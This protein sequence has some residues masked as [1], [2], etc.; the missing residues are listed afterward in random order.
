MMD[1]INRF[2][3]ICDFS[4]TAI[5]DSLP[6]FVINAGPA[7]NSIY[8]DYSAVEL[9]MPSPSLYFTSRRPKI[10]KDFGS[11]TAFPERILYSDEFV[12]GQAND[13]KDTRLK[14]GKHLSVAGVDNNNGSLLYFKG[15][16]RSGDLYTVQFYGREGKTVNNKRLHSRISKKSSM[17]GAISFAENGDAYFIS[18]RP[19]GMGGRDIWYAMKKGKNSFFPPLNL[20]NL[21]TPLNEECVYV[22]PDGNTLYFSSNG[23]PGFGG[24]D[25]YKSVR[26][27]DGTWGDPVNMGYPVNSPDNDLYYRLT[28][29]TTLALLSSGRRGGFGGLDVYYVKKDSRIPFELSGN[30]TDAKT[31]KTLAATVRLI[32]RITGMTA[33]STNNDTIQQRY[34]LKME[35]TGNYEL[36]VEAPGYHPNTENFVNPVVRHTKL[37][38][39]FT[40]EKLNRPYTLNGYITDL[41]TGRPVAA[42][43][44][45]KLSGRDDEL[46]RTVSD[47]STGY[48]SLRIGDKDNFDLIARATTYFD[49][50][51]ALPLKNVAEEMGNKNITL[52]KSVNMYVSTG[53]VKSESDGSPLK[54][55]IS[56]SRLSSGQFVQNTVSDVKGKYDLIL[57]DNGPFLM[58]V[59]SEGHFFANRVLQFTKDSMMV[60]RNF[61]LRKMESGAKLVIENI[62]FNTGN[63][64]LRPESFASLNKLVNLLKENPKIKIE[65]SGHTD[66]TGSAAT[67]KSLSR[68]R[69]LSVRNYLISQGIAAQRVNYE[70]YG[71]DRPVAPNTTAAGR[72]ANRR[73]EIEIL[74]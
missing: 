31:G 3:A 59:T 13:A 60:I 19:G 16:K 64:T 74:D 34:L 26:M 36:H 4:A 48:Y 27:H 28:S 63:A 65:V 44:L 52:Q 15:K 2:F 33:G 38:Q 35:N 6:V 22:T 46:Y 58:E 43:I 69:A 67:N 42:E 7:V 20:Q 47:E 10:S 8:D 72:A 25:V 53:L 32:D 29:D 61:N 50:K 66:N 70:G 73:V 30:V 56:A 14:S 45:V 24:Y 37:R 9:L 23:L 18:D 5:Q 17:E 57:P 41:R 51:E 68:N 54:A 21:N 12:N 62:L 55:N 11:Y 39:D 40:L 1:K 49:H 71:F